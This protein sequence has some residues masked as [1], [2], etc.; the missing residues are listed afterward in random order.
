MTDR[1]STDQIRDAIRKGQ[2][3]NPVVIERLA[4]AFDAQSQAM[5]EALRENE[6]LK[7]AGCAA[8]EHIDLVEQERDQRPRWSLLIG[9]AVGGYVMGAATRLLMLAVGW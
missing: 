2:Q 6:D 5:A 8:I 4:N 7:A 3:V 9:C 1:I